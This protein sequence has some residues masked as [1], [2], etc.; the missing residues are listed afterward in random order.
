MKIFLSFLQGKPGHPIP[1]YGFWEYYIK[2]GIVESGHSWLELQDVDWAYGLVPKSKESQE[3]WMDNAWKK[4]IAF[5]KR[6]KVDLFLSYLY[7]SQIDIDSIEEIKKLGIPVV[8][9]F[10]DNIREF[11]KTPIQFKAFDLNWVPEYKAL[12]MYKKARAAY[13]HLPMPM[14]VEP[15]YRSLPKLE[16]PKV[17]FIGSNDIQ[18]QLLFEKA[19]ALDL[20]FELNIYGTAWQ[21]GSHRSESSAMPL[22]GLKSKLFN[23]FEYI[24]KH[25]ALNWYRKLKQ[26]NINIPISVDLKKAIKGKPSFE[27]YIQITKASYVTLGVNR[28]PSYAFPLHKPDTYSRLRDIEAPML[29]ACYL[30]EWT[31]G[32]DKMYVIGTEIETYKT[33]EEL[34]DKAKRLVRDKITRDNLRAQ[35]QQKAL[36]DFTIS[37]SIA[38]IQK[39][40][41]I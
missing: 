41:S 36:S 21:D 7:P 33:A 37:N 4:T 2:N 9:F 25:G 13:I 6:N 5:L 17:S 29:G 11:K 34:V 8:N 38:Q 26:R 35:G 23:Q 16:M 30:T 39:H 14:W 15:K 31:E 24:N 40:L 28:Y 12:E 18:R 19:I 32:I 22:L 27:D 1:A 10:C 3:Q 20:N